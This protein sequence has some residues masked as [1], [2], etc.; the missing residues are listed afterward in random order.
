M[1]KRDRAVE[2]ALKSAILNH[3]RDIVIHY[4]YN[5]QTM[6]EDSDDAMSTEAYYELLHFFMGKDNAEYDAI[7]GPMI[8]SILYGEPPSDEMRMEAVV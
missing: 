8:R 1:S 5:M 7:L 4:V 2:H 3:Y 6:A